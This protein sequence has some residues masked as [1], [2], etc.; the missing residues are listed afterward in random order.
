M[1]NWH[2]NFAVV[3]WSHTR[4]KIT[5]VNDRLILEN[6]IYKNICIAVA[7]SQFL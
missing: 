7:I 4:L 2:V 5:E 1:Y 6:E 3:Q